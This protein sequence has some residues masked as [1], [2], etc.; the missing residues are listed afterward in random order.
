MTFLELV[1]EVLER[2]RDDTVNT[3]NTSS[4]SKL[5]GHYVNDTKRQVENAW[6]WEVLGARCI[7]SVI[8]SV[9][10]YTVTGSGLRQ[11]D[12]TVNLTTSGSQ[13]PLRLVNSKWIEDQEQLTT[14]TTGTPA[15]YAWDGNNGVDSSVKLWPL[16]NGNYSISFNMVVPQVKL[17]SDDDVLLVPSHLVVEGAY[18]RALVERGEDGGLNSSE[19]YNLFKSSLADAIAIEAARDADSDVWDAT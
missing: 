10:T 7:V 11:K 14:S 5:I 19:A 4:Y 15:Y 6:N 12:V 17:V 2:L 9:N 8:P 3:V 16:P 1:N 18:A 13:T